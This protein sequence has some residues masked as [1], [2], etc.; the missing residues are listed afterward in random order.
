MTRT[1][2]RVGGVAA[3][4]GIALAVPVVLAHRAGLPLAALLT[5][6]LLAHLLAG[7]AL[8][9]EVGGRAARIVALARALE[10]P[11]RWRTAW[12]AQLAGDAAGAVT[13]SRS[14]TE[15]AKLLS[16][17]RDGGRVGGLAAIAVGETAFE[18]GGLLVVGAALLLALDEGRAAAAAVFTYAGVVGCVLTGLVVFAGRRARRRPVPGWWTR[19]GLRPGRWRLLERISRDFRLRA[20]A[21]RSL[22]PRAVAAAGAATLLHQAAR[23]ATFPAL[24]WAATADPSLDW[25]ALTL[26]PFGL[27]YL[28]ALLPPPGG[29][30]GIEVG[31]AALLGD[32]LAPERLPV[33][34]LWWRVYTHLLT[35]AV[36]A[37]AIALLSARRRAS[38]RRRQEDLQRLHG[39]G[40]VQDH[41]AAVHHPHRATP[42]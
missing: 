24:A 20:D 3:S 12:L 7:T 23:A 2:L 39:Q 34:L 9:A 36:G 13:P 5:L 38:P 11:L 10:V 14:G 42:P 15:P 28:G 35:A 6:P 8:L 30:G 27:V 17:R 37:G 40:T 33:L 18:V 1:A 41:P 21:L 31:F 25:V 32:A 16:M 29:G 22:P 4:L 19:L 26:G